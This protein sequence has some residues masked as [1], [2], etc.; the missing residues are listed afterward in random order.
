MD[1]QKGSCLASFQ[2]VGAW[3]VDREGDHVVDV[4]IIETPWVY[5][6]VH[7]E[8]LSHAE[9]DVVFHGFGGRDKILGGGMQFGWFP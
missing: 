1:R 6:D 4:Y 8:L 3:D 7:Y 5:V 9:R 2:I